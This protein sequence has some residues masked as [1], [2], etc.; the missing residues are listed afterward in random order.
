MKKYIIKGTNEEEIIKKVANHFNVP[1]DFVKY[2]IVNREKTFFGKTKELTLKIWI[3]KTV[4]D[5]DEVES[6]I[7]EKEKEVE[8]KE[9]IEKKEK[10]NIEILKSGI[11]ITIQENFESN[12]SNERLII[13]EL[14]RREIKDPNLENV[15]KAL[16]EKK[17]EK[18]KIAEYD[19]SYYIDALLRIELRKDNME[20]VIV[21]YPPHRGNHI[22]KDQIMTLL[23]ENSILYGVD[24]NII[25]EIVENRIYDKEIIVARGKP[26]EKGKNAEIITLFDT[27][28]EIKI[29]KDESGKANLRDLNLI[30][31]VTK[32]EKLVQKIFATNG[33]K[34]KN[35]LG[36]EIIPEP[37]NDKKIFVGKN[38][39]LTENEEFLIADI[40][41]QLVDVNGNISVQPLYTVSGNVDY[42]VG[43]IEFNGSVHILGRVL[44]GF[45]IKAKGDVIIEEIVEDAIIET[46]GNVKVK[47]GILGKEDLKGYIKA[48][49]NVEAKFIQ[50]SKIDS[51]GIVEA[52]ENILHSDINAKNDI[53]CIKGRGKIIGG[54]LIA[55]KNIVT[56]YVGTE[57]GILTELTVG[58]LPDIIEKNKLIDEEL[59]K[60]TKEKE[61]TD[62][63]ADNLRMQEI[64]GKLDPK[65]RNLLLNLTK[66]KFEINKKIVE[67]RN[68]KNILVNALNEGRKG[69]IHVFNELYPGAVIKIGENQLITKEIFRFSTFFFDNDKKEISTL[70]CELNE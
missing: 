13:K 5:V 24:K 68:E 16:Y 62:T 58:A 48:E 7:V 30:I 52:I 46:E 32:G 26:S 50:Y 41:G 59:R 15:K 33:I 31:N 23:A 11:F 35:V 17:G 64:Q 28:S 51:G 43:N 65:Y 67:L 60:I 53:I 40:D 10:F 1:I 66:K 9:K 18:V 27:S 57:F 54:S 55:G 70:P 8:I 61:R 12:S 29:K 39:S 34:G 21:A 4:I 2:E 36:V 25:D 3:E 14:E 69:K 19:K 37:G 49:G 56:K 63:E 6:I 38:T 47:Q 20:A 45:I 42:S 44:E 22:S